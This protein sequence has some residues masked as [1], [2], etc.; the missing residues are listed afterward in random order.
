VPRTTIRFALMSAM[1]LSVATMKA[2]NA[3]PI[4][5]PAASYSEAYCAGFIAETPVPHDLSVM[6]GGDDDFH[7]VLRQFVTGE[8]IFIA[9]RN[10]AD[11]AVGT[12]YSVVR[13]AT[14]IFETTRYD[15]ENSFLRKL[16][17]PYL[18]VA[19]VTVTHS[20]SKGIVANIKFSC[21]AVV[22]GDILVP[23]QTRA[24]PDYT[25][26]PPLDH[27]APLDENKPHGR[28][29]ASNS[30][31]G[32]LG[33]GNIIYLNLG[34]D[35]GIQAGKR[36]RIYKRLSPK[37]FGAY[38]HDAAPPETIGEAVVLSVR[39]KSSVA[40]IV[41]SYREINAGDYVEAE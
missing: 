11:I 10:G 15:G 34:N 26:S 32:Y 35:Q 30:N 25:V 41:G 7:A 4:T 18:D 17:T 28:I 3:A 37:E 5:K 6:G 36:V 39:S 27:F 12:E 2:Q 20:T 22:P 24:I 19:Q 23:F 9:K 40:L 31:F 16:G 21:E 38:S 33:R 14:D 1:L 13:P 8:S 29:A